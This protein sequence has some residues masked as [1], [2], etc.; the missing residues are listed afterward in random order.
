[1]SLFEFSDISKSEETIQRTWEDF[2][3][4]LATG[5]FSYNELDAAKANTTFLKVF[6]DLF[7]HCHPFFDVSA[8]SILACPTTLMRAGRLRPADPDPTYSR[9]IPNKDYIINNIERYFLL[10]NRIPPQILSKMP[11]VLKL[12]ER[13]RQYRLNSSSK[14]T[15]KLAE[16][17]AK[18]HFE[19]MPDNDF[20]VIPQTSSGRRKYVPIGFLTPDILVNN[21][22]QVMRDGGL[23]E[24]G[25]LCS[26][27]HNSW[28]RNVAGRLRDDFTYSVSVVYNT[29]PWCNPTDEQKKRIESTAQDILIA[30]KL[31]PESSLADL[32]KDISMPPEL[33]KAHQANDKAV[34]QAYGF[35]GKLNSESECVAELMKMYQKLVNQKQE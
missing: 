11:N 12:L 18:F 3:S 23:Y 21:K 7:S 10:I 14:P 32:Y 16:T 19:N 17:P 9:F 35:W 31:Y 24:F 13:I 8:E 30:R 29:F 20:L 1:M 26:N 28:V 33:R 25:I 2:R 27:V 4:A 22:L 34:M 6:D 5:V 15:Q